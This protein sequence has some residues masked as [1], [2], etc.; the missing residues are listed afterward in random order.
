MQEQRKRNRSRVLLVI[1]MQIVM[2]VVN[3]NNIMY[4]PV[5]IYTCIHT[6][7]STYLDN[8]L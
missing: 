3:M 6:Y 5:D 4:K 2:K 1:H 8:C 7:I